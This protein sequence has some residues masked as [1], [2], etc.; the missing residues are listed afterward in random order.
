MQLLCFVYPLHEY[1]TTACLVCQVAG[2]GAVLWGA[3]ACGALV[4]FGWGVDVGGL[5]CRSL[6]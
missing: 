6:R 5:C 2:L 3:A 1:C 4:C